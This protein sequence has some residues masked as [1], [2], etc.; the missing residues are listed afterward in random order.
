LLEARGDSVSIGV[1]TFTAPQ[2][3]AI[4]RELKQFDLVDRDTETGEWLIADAYRK[5]NKEKSA[6][7][8]DGRC[9]PGQGV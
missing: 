4:F 6:S 2:R 5:T 1:I 7:G 8:G 3:D 9:L